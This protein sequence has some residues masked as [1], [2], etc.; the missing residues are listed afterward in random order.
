[1][2]ERVGNG[3]RMR[4]LDECRTRNEQME[5][6]NEKGKRYGRSVSGHN[7]PDERQ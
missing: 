5:R 1:M 6:K 7:G 3:K 2:E 4:D